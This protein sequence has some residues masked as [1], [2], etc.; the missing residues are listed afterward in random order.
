MPDYTLYSFW[1]SSCSARLRIALNLKCIPFRVVPVDLL[2]DEQASEAHRELNP[3]R[4]V[5]LLLGKNGLRIGQSMAALEYLEEAHPQIQLLP[6]ALDIEGRAIVRA[7]ANIIACDTQPVTNLRILKRVRSIGGNAEDWARKLV[8][9]NLAAYEAVITNC[10]GDYSYGDTVTISDACLL[11]AVWN[12][13]MFG[14]DVTQF[15]VI[16]KIVE[17][18]ERLGAVQQSSY[19][20]QPDTPEEFKSGQSC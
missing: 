2:K 20:K 17:R 13:R 10:A 11:P 6:P 3:S 9:D 1:K 7:L 12:A 4:S 14:I 8:L 19:T 18:L 15:S 16:S 5:P